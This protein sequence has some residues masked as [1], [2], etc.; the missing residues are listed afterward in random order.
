[1]GDLGAPDIPGCEGTEKHLAVFLETL[2]LSGD[3][4][5]QESLCG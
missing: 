3:P 5:I 2:A 4:G 1:M